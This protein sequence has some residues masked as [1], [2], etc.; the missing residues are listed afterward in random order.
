[1]I[2][3]IIYNDTPTCRALAPCMN[4]QQLIITS[5]T[6]TVNYSVNRDI[7]QLIYWRLAVSTVSTKSVC[8][9]IC[10]MLDLVH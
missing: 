1:M 5:T 9:Y 10:F 4:S 6:I 8:T 3:M 2:R 7:L